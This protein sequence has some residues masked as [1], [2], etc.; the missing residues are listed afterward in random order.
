MFIS[1]IV[2]ELIEDI[3]T[4]HENWKQYS[5]TFYNT[6]TTKQIWTANGI[7][8]ID[9]YPNIKA[10]NIFEQIAIHR[11]IKYSNIK[12]SITNKTKEN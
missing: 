2:K 3:K 11:A 12:N 8:F 5:Y 10:F 1:P 6:R 7:L 4:N 9:F